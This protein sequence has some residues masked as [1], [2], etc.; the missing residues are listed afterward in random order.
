M[1]NLLDGFEDLVCGFFTGVGD[2]AFV[3]AHLAFV[4]SDVFGEFADVDEVKTV[5]EGGDVITIFNAH[6]FQLRRISCFCKLFTDGFFDAFKE[7]SLSAFYGFSKS[8]KKAVAEVVVG[9]YGIQSV[10]A[11]FYDSQDFF[12]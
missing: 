8:A 3:C 6:F 5:E 7:V 4:D 12:V 9:V 1:A 10:S 11:S 2:A